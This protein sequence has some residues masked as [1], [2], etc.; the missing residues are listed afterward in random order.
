MAVEPILRRSPEDYD[1]TWEWSGMDVV[2]QHAKPEDEKAF[3]FLSLELSRFNRRHHPQADSLEEVLR[4]RADRASQL[5]RA[6][7]PHQLILMAKVGGK[8]V[9]YALAVIA[10]PDPSSDNGTGLCGLLD[11]VYVDESAR[12]LGI[13]RQ[14][15]DDC[16]TWIRHQGARRV[17]LQ[18]YN[19]NNH[20]RHVYE[21]QGF[22]QYAVS[23]E[24][25]LD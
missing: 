13:G 19:W 7:D 3:I 6:S 24:K 5:F 9:G 18:M 4:A 22:V 14:L 1:H 20:A 25:T 17:K 15:I 23:L 11:E 16:L 2:I 8:D 12:G 10:H 21:K